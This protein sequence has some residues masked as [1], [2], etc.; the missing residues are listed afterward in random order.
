MRNMTDLHEGCP[1][2]VRDLIEDGDG[3]FNQTEAAETLGVDPKTL[4]TPSDAP[5]HR[6]DRDARS[7]SPLRQRL[8][9]SHHEPL[10]S[11]FASTADDI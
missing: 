1:L 4:C 7:V 2:Y 9:A 3:Q 11:A 6:Y 5:A 10:P 8:P